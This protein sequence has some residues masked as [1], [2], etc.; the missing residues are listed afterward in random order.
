MLPFVLKTK[1]EALNLLVDALVK[2]IL[3]RLAILAKDGLAGTAAW[4]GRVGD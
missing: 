4:I 3:P 2:V 1:V